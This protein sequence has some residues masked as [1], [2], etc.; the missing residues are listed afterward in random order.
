MNKLG[1]LA[2]ASQFAPRLFQI[3]R[4]T[5]IGLGVGL[6]VL[7]GLFVWAA[8]ALA[9][10]LFGQAQGWL[11]AA[12]DAAAGPAQE[13]LEQVERVAP[14]AREQLDTHLGEYL[15]VLTGEPQP[16]RDV[17]GEDLGPVPRY[18]GLV[19][20][21]WLRDG[22]SAAVEFTGR[23]SYTAVLDHFAQNF[24]AL[25]YAQ[26]VLSANRDAETHAYTKGAERYNVTVT[27][28]G[29]EQVTVRIEAKRP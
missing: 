15:P 10:W 19:R 8:V 18:P 25:G 3:R 26:A 12:Q 4:G 20:S 23:A 2:L 9:G 11:G 28:S 24:S 21:A 14:A 27:R 29:R 16:A 1:L 5:W 13:V 22:L 17:S 6:V 7:L